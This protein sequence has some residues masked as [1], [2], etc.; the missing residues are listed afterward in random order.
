MRL[1]HNLKA[2]VHRKGFF[3]NPKATPSPKCDR[4]N[5]VTE[6]QSNED[7]ETENKATSIDASQSVSES[8]S[9]SEE[10]SGS[11]SAKFEYHLKAP[12]FRESGSLSVKCLRID[13]AIV[14][15]NRQVA[16][17]QLQLS[18]KNKPKQTVSEK[19][20]KVESQKAPRSLRSIS[21]QKVQ[22]SVDSPRRC[23]M[24]LNC[25]QDGNSTKHS[26]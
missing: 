23:I 7:S 22:A 11:E 25:C 6:S 1:L 13:T 14:C 18:Q 15:H 5:G 17:I 3:L 20:T 24:H 26:L 2:C 12:R 16:L 10:K 8:M 19:N 4:V 9:P 21:T